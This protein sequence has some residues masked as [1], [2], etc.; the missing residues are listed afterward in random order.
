MRDSIGKFELALA[1]DPQFALAHVGIAD[2][3]NFLVGYGYSP[4]KISTPKAKEELN[5]AFAL[6]ENL[7]EAHASMGWIYFNY[8]WNW[9]AAQKS[10]LWTIIPFTKL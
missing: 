4:P 6:N 5:K 8:D 1:K 10:F 2:A 7:S 3:Y 9:D